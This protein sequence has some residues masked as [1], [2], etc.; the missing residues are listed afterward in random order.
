MPGEPKEVTG[1]ANVYCADKVLLNKVK[2]NMSSKGSSCS[3][4]VG[5][6]RRGMRIQPLGALPRLG[7]VNFSMRTRL[8]VRESVAVDVVNNRCA[9]G[10]G[11][12][13]EDS[14][15]KIKRTG[16]KL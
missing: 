1:G 11:A 4:E 13:D 5:R 2:K 14:V 12:R 10:K 15:W 8:T 3:F 6:Y 9:E 7:F 16:S